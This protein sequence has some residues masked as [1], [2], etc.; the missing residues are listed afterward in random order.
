MLA[1]FY[2]LDIPNYYETIEISVVGLS[3]IKNLLSLLNF[4]FCS[5][6]IVSISKS[7]RK[8]SLDEAAWDEQAHKIV[9]QW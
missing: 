4:E 6:W 9:E 7:S 1:G 8:K 5:P 2:H 3:T